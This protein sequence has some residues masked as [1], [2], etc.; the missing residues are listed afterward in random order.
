MVPYYQGSLDGF[1]GIY[2]CVN[3]INSLTTDLACDKLFSA[4]IRKIGKNLARIT[5]NGTTE[6]EL[7]QLIL[8]PTIQYLKTQNI[9]LSYKQ[10]ENVSTLEEYW[11]TIQSH[12]EENGSGS[13]IIGMIGVREHWTCVSK[14]T[15][16]TLEFSDS[17]ALKKFYRMFV[18][19]GEPT[20]KRKHVLLPSE[21]FLLSIK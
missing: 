17:G 3:A 7:K 6:E 5:L 18:T 14:V 21:T 4:I 10:I 16:K 19:I 2:S 20:K 8:V 9:N 15:E 13:I 1:C 12:Y 11:K